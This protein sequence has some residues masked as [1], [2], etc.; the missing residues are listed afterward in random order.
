MAPTDST[1]QKTWCRAILCHHKVI[2]HRD[3]DMKSLESPMTL[4]QCVTLTLNHKSNGAN[5]FVT[6]AI[7]QCVNN[8]NAVLHDESN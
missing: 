8:K 4:T 5:I 6:M 2:G 1:Y 3:I 7:E